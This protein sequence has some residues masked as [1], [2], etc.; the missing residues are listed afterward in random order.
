MHMEIM[1]A[2]DIRWSALVKDHESESHDEASS[3]EEHHAGDHVYDF[4]DFK[5]AVVQGIHHEGKRL[6]SDMPRWQMSDD[7]L[8]DLIAYLKSLP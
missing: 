7:D 1:N 2:P 6:N 4:N 8:N 5:M 3:D